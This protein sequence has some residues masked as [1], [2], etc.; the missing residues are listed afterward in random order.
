[1]AMATKRSAQIKGVLAQNFKR[2]KIIATVGPVTN[3]YEAIL[4]MIESG[5][6]ALRL[7]FSHGTHEQHARVIGWARAA[8]KKIGK[9]IAI[10]QDLQGPKLRIGELPAEG[11]EL[12]A[13]EN[14]KL[15]YQADFFTDGII[16]TQHDFADKV[17]PGET[18]FLYDG[19]FRLSVTKI[20]NRVIGARVQS[21]GILLSRKGINLPDTDLQGAI[22]TPKDIADIDFALKNDVDYIAL[23]FVQTP[24]DVLRLK[25]H[26]QQNKSDMGVIA[27]IETKLALDNVE[28]IVEVS[29]GVM[30]ARGD[31]ATEAG[32][33]VVPIVQ[34][35]I[36]GLARKHAKIAI[37]ATQM[38]VSMLDS[39]QPS[40]ADVS[41]VATA[42][43]IG[44]DAVM[45][46][47]ESAV[48]RF[49]IETIQTMKRII[50]YTEQNLPVEPLFFNLS[51]RST[52][53]SVTAA[54]ITLAHQ[55]EAKAIITETSS[56]KT[57]R[58]IAASRPR[59]PIIMATNDKKVA[60]QLAI[61]YGSK[62]FYF[63]SA[64]KLSA[65]SLAR[66]KT[67]RSLQRGDYVVLT[68]GTQPG[69]SGG[70]STLQLHR[71][72]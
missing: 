4:A 40:R 45:L 53:G 34:R 67:L 24:G 18:I 13:G 49:P 50:K 3:S 38:L 21:G 59:M 47:E 1:M 29:D 8:A 26:L 30:V 57:G 9:P 25:E 17:R 64:K 72:K 56:G 6:N 68:Y 27:K 61:V 5:V 55:L 69:V 33:E 54:V 7:N 48:G 63:P 41:D 11:L 19:K 23:S 52:E 46:S 60:Q 51:D 14:V 15:A 62:P 32:S 31:L 43:I 65:E 12:V 71:V 28:A 44:T 58:T 16:P 35:E 36:V 39:P 20:H 42:V 70:T 22:I 37:V 2:T 66:L 10:I